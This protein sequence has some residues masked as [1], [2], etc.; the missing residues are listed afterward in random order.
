MIL[1]TGAS[2]FI[3]KWLV[4]LAIEKFGQ[5]EVIALTSKPIDYCQFILHHGYTF[6]SN[7][8]DGFQIDKVIHAGAFIPKSAEQSNSV[9]ESNSNITNIAYLLDHLPKSV[10][11][12][13][14]LSTVDVYDINE[15]L[16]NE[17]SL[18]RPISLYG[19]SKYYCERMLS[20]W[21]TLMA[22]QF[23]ILRIGHV[24]GEGEESYSKLIPM[25]IK[26]VLNK[27][28]PQIF[29]TGEELRSFMYVQ[30]C[31][32]LILSSLEA[33]KSGIILNVA[34]PQSFTVRHIIDLIISLSEEP[35]LD[36][37]FI[38]TNRVSRSIFFDTAKM[39]ENIGMPKTELRDGL[40]REIQDRKSVV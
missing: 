18:I 30:D 13:V 36:I 3:G 19:D 25:T 5:N 11:K 8:F 14:F 12:I 35:A 37:N 23:V 31:C 15:K 28:P 10:K 33:N 9:A 22:V 21:C 40:F 16:I 2:G 29:G 17:Q 39:Q 38:P 20:A 4:K 7:A 24:F 6:D 27:R 1:I 32:D 34:S 26:N